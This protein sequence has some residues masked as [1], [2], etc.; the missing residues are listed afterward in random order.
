MAAEGRIWAR[1]AKRR[2]SFNGAAAGWPRKVVAF[3]IALGSVLL[4]W[5][6][7]RMAAEGGQCGKRFRAQEW[8]QWGRGRMAAEGVAPGPLRTAGV[9]LQWGRGRMAAEGV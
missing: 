5:G 1:D 8:L 4:Q 9:G 3:L 7:G 6:R 2:R